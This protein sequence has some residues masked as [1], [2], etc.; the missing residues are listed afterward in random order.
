[1]KDLIIADN[2]PLAYNFDRD[3]GLP[4]SFWFEDK[5]DK[6]LYNIMPLLIFL[7]KINDVRK[8]IEKF[9]SFDKIDYS[10]VI[11]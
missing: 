1:M 9:V 8:F 4:I 10:N 2:S 6:E 5:N 7:S 11:K 3:N